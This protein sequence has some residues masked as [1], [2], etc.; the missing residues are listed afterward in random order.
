MNKSIV[1]KPNGKAGEYAKYAANF[2]NGCPGKCEY[3]YNQKGPFAATLGGDE[4]IIKKSLGSSENAI[5]LFRKDIENAAL[6][7][8]LRSYQEHG[9]FFSFVSDPW[10]PE[11]TET[12]LAAIAVCSEYNIPVI[13]LSKFVGNIKKNAA[14]L[15]SRGMYGFS[16]TMADELEPGTSSHAER[17]KALKTLH[18]EGL[19]TWASIE[20][21]ITIELSI[22][23]IREALPFCQHFRIGLNSN[24]DSNPRKRELLYLFNF[25]SALAYD[26]PEANLKV[27]FKESFN[28]EAGFTS[29]FMD[30]F[31]WIVD[32][33]Y[34]HWNY[35]HIKHK[36]LR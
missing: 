9:I 16:L 12:T 2:F 28:K 29:D 13:T 14:N 31:P 17:I 27:L 33:D 10:T 26:K 6:C 11:A 32:T 19:C 30:G 23:A 1:Y 34:K 25:L 35:M 3:C 4:A 8:E 7:G 5:A 20:P 36:V 22:K 18:Q 15:P 24:S 21:I